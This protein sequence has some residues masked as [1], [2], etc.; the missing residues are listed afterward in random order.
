MNGVI[1]VYKPQNITSF[2]V[3]RIIKKIS[4]IKK[5]GHTGTL[6][7]MATGVLPIC[8]GGSTKIVDFI[9]NE[10]K[11][12]RAKL[13]LGLIT[14][15]YDREGK[16][17]KE[18]DASKILEEEVVN[19]INS[20]KG[21]IIQ[22]PPMYS[23]IKIKGERLYN[24]ARKGIEVER[25]GRKINI[26][27]IE[28]LKVNL[29]YV[30]FKVNCSKGTYIRSL[31]YDIGN[32]LGM[33]ATMWELER[34]KTGNFSIENSINLEDINEENIQEFIIPA[35]KALSKYERIEI[36]EYFSRLLKNGVKVKDKRLLDKIKANDILRVYQED[37]FIGLGQ[38]TK[39]G[40]KI[41][42][43]LV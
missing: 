24:L 40:F 36:D 29:P 4:R 1:N 38:K 11:E 17:L 6:D 41:V 28:V 14:D 33:G 35:E 43:L 9:M 31:C 34:T 12:Y 18:E 30:E 37:R 22:I 13:K 25:E 15:T 16:V 42:K 23:A 2:D 21:E 27:N 32:K 3:V 26:Y 39:E 8:L 7:P 5:V 20:F 19:C 10:H